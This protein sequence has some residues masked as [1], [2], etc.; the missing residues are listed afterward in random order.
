MISAHPQP[1]KSLFHNLYCLSLVPETPQDLAYA[2]GPPLDQVP[3]HIFGTYSGTTWHG[4]P[5]DAKTLAVRIMVAVGEA[6]TARISI[7][8]V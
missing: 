8:T 1:S 7:E 2:F 4:A 6:G 5:K 3:Q